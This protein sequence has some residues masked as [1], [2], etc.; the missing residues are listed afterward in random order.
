[1]IEEGPF[2][3][4]GIANLRRQGEELPGHLEHVVDVTGLRGPPVDPVVQLVGR[5]EI[6]VLA[7]TAGRK[8]VML[9]DAVPEEPRGRAVGL[10][11]RH[12]ITSQRAQELGHLGIAVLAGEDVLTPCQRI[13]DRAVLK[14]VG[15]DQPSPVARIGVEIGQDL[16]HPA[17][18]GPQHFLDLCVVE[19]GEDSLGPAGELDFQFQGGTVARMA[20]GVTQPGVDLVEHI[21]G[22]PEAVQVEPARADVA[23][24]HL[25]KTVRPSARAPR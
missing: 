1:M 17:E 19:L 14:T 3:E 24:G 10:V 13:E 4:L 18:L 5:A 15:E 11:A 22:R 21:P 20:V 6:L 23:P 9:H 16:V 7:V 8:A 2:V 12:E 25:G